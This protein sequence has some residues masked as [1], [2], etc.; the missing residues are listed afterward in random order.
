MSFLH[1]IIIFEMFF[2]CD[3]TQI[4]CKVCSANTYGLLLRQ[5]EQ[6]L[7]GGDSADLYG[8]AREARN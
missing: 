6:I 5:C 1:Y 4:L 3:L 8:K 2:I 7:E